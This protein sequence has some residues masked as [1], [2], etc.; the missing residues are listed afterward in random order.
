MPVSVLHNLMEK[1]RRAKVS[2]GNDCS[3]NTGDVSE[4]VTL[5]PSPKQ[6]RH[7]YPNTVR[8]TSAIKQGRCGVNAH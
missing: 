6:R 4:D 8:P 3:A 5:L 7:C 1:R 2:E